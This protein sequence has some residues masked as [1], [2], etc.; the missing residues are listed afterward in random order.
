M[1]LRGEPLEVRRLL[2]GDGGHIAIDAFHDFDGDGIFQEHYEVM[3][4]DVPG[5]LVYRDNG[6]GQL[7]VTID[8][9]LVPNI[10]SYGDYYSGLSFGRYFAV[11]PD[12]Q[13]PHSPRTVRTTPEIEVIDLTAQQ[14]GRLVEVGYWWTGTSSVTIFRD[15]DANGR[16]D[17]SDPL[18]EGSHPVS[19]LREGENRPDSINVVDGK[20]SIVG[21]YDG[22]KHTYSIGP[23]L[24]GGL[25]ATTSEEVTI[26]YEATVY[27]SIEFGV[28]DGG[29][30]EAIVFSDE[31]GDG[32]TADDRP[33]LLS[34]LDASIRITGQ[35]FNG[36][37]VDTVAV[38]IDFSFYKYQLEDVLPGY[39]TAEVVVEGD[40][41]Q[42]LANEPLTRHFEVGVGASVYIDFAAYFS[43][44]IVDTISTNVVSDA[45]DLNLQGIQ[46][47]LFRDDGD[48]AFDPQTDTLLAIDST[49]TQA[50]YELPGV[51]HGS[52]ILVPRIGRHFGGGERAGALFFTALST[53]SPEA[54]W[55]RPARLGG[56][57]YVDA[58]RNGL[59]EPRERVLEDIV[60]RLEGVDVF[61]NS[62]AKQTT[63]R[64]DGSYRFFGLRPGTYSLIQEQPAGYQSGTQTTGKF[65]G[66]PS[67]NRIDNIIVEM[68]E[69]SE[70]YD[71]GEYG[72]P[73]L[74]EATPDNRDHIGGYEP[75]ASSA[76]L[77]D[78]NQSGT[79]W[80]A[81]QYGVAGSRPIAGD[82]NADGYDGAGFFEP[83][84][85]LFRL[86]NT[87]R[88]TA[89]DDVT[90]FV[91]GAAGFIPIAG[92]WNWDGRDTVGAYDPDSSTFYLRNSNESGLPD[93]GAFSYG[94]PGWVPLAGD[95]DG[96]GYD[97]IGVYDPET[98]TFYLR[99]SLSAG[100]PDITPFNYGVPGMK[101]IVGDWNDDGVVTIGAYNPDTATYFLR[102]TNNSGVADTVTNYG[103]SGW[104]PIVGNWNT[105]R[106]ALTKP[107]RRGGG[108]ILFDP[109][110]DSLAKRIE[111]FR[112]LYIDAYLRGD[113]LNPGATLPATASQ[114][115][116]G[117]QSTASAFLSFALPETNQ[118][119]TTASLAAPPTSTTDQSDVTTLILEDD[120]DSLIEQLALDRISPR[121]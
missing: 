32:R 69:V 65:G 109:F 10:S 44:A 45:P 66:Q 115:A 36:Q 54:L 43:K 93:A 112:L 3:F 100:S 79:A 99:N 89:D 15:L 35:A 38:P 107:P 71:F 57:V 60:M 87:N 37:V 59:H 12:Y 106:A 91:F 97:G 40:Q 20:T 6:D 9:L 74:R 30:I 8:Q 68:G 42:L 61:G 82:W 121:G 14:T 108:V 11:S 18:L 95:W 119:D 26:E 56:D 111:R 73:N 77:S 22:D 52:Y 120:S 28:T 33:V 49:D 114:G 103:G 80:A 25:V 39:Y 110:E 104:E 102:D 88:N 41:F 81:Y 78:S 4:D 47:A 83:D 1:A 31:T 101:P 76:Y 86:K 62:V 94:R 98:A 27:K 117:T 92:D 50:Q 63:T 70:E 7:D 13:V 17:A 96:D 48:G 67:A 29:A 34:D 85:A 118:L 75:S 19:L 72:L 5:V 2:T 16:R 24:T 116:T 23:L 90:P 55:F 58:N 113:G 84:T 21:H 51:S 64:T 105:D 53:Q 46:V